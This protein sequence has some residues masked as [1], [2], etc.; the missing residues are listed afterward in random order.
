[1]QIKYI[2]IRKTGRIS[3]VLTSLAKH[4]LNLSKMQLMPVIDTHYKN[5]FFTGFVFNS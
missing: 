2:A 5:A 3:K 4:I 1:L